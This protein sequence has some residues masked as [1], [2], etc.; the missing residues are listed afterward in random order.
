M[1]PSYVSFVVQQQHS[2]FIEDWEG[3]TYRAVYTVKFTEFVYVLHCFNKKSKGG[4]KTPLLDIAL[5]KAR[6]RLA[7]ADYKARKEPS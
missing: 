6:L 7:E 2:A 4:A 5:I 3:N 1:S